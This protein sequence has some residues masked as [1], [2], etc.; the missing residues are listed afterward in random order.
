MSTDY[1]AIYH[2]DG[3][4]S[5]QK[6]KATENQYYRQAT[7]RKGFSKSVRKHIFEKT[8][9][10]CG[11][12]G[13]ELPEKWHIDHMNSLSLL[14]DFKGNSNGANNLDNLIASC[15]PCNLY[16][17]QDDVEGFRKSIRDILQRQNN[18]N[19]QYRIGKKFGLIEEIDK[20]IIFYFELSDRRGG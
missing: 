5:Y 14:S 11:Y 6:N 3:K 9:G 7:G 12:C 13:C 8:N 4:V 10:R 16:K 2:A 19:R 20:P 18:S 17:A 15:P 1:K